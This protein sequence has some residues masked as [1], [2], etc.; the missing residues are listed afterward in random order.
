M[1]HDADHWDFVHSK[2]YKDDS[3]H[4]QYAENKEKLFPRGSIVVELGGG[5]GQDALYFLKQGHSVLLFD[6]SGFALKIA[7]EKAKKE[8]LAKKLVVR[9]IDFG[10]HKLP[11]KDGSVD[12][13]YS[14]VALNYFPQKETIGIF[15]EV[16]RVLKTGAQAYLGLKS[17]GDEEEMRLLEKTSVEYEKNVFILNDQ[18]VSRFS[19]EQLHHML[20]QA[21][22]SNSQIN[23]FTENLG[24]LK[25]DHTAELKLTDITFT[26]MS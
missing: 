10:Q 24:N 3:W 19:D 25:K 20:S 14:R 5:T 1:I 12:V 15:N 7:Q 17:Q 21:H 23:A 9:Q 22:I 4:S 11:I 8:R 6:I 16:N 2:T 26:K 13:V 18:I